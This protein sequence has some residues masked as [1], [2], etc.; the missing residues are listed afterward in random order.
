MLVRENPRAQFIT[1]FVADALTQRREARGMSK[2]ELS[3]RSGIS[4]PGIR[5][6]GNHRREA[7]LY[8]IL[9]L[10]EALRLDVPRVLRE[11]QRAA[12]NKFPGRKG[13]K[14]E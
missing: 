8:V 2:E 9:L 3:R 4:A 10:G 14:A 7:S 6:I 1:R 13:R 12:K 5:L 11:A